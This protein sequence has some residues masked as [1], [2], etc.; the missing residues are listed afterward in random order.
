V[1]KVGKSR[2]TSKTQTGKP[3]GIKHCCHGRSKSGYFTNMYILG[4]ARK[5]MIS[6]LLFITFCSCVSV[7]VY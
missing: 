4:M 3:L 1:D 2:G 7:I 6:R 5:E